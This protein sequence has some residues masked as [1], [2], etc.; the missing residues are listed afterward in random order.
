MRIF[1]KAMIASASLAGLGSYS[2]VV[3]AQATCE[4]F[5]SALSQSK[6]LHPHVDI[7][8][9]GSRELCF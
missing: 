6:R 7:S 8:N 9:L 5:E 4:H 1:M 2:A 3:N